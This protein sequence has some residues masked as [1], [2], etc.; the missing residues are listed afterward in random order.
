MMCEWASNSIRQGP[1]LEIKLTCS[2]I[3]KE[4]AFNPERSLMVHRGIKA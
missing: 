3:V 4:D 1:V 2:A